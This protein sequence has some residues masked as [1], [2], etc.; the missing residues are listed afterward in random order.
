[1]YDQWLQTALR[2]MPKGKTQQGLAECLGLHQT[3]ISRMARGE[4]RIKA[5]RDRENL[6]VFGTS[7]ADD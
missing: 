2:H 3:Q 4:R 5:C 6:S 7:G 1:M